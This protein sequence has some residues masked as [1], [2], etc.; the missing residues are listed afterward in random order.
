MCSS[1]LS[2]LSRRAGKAVQAGA[3]STSCLLP[4]VP[5]CEGT[6][7]LPP[8]GASAETGSV[9][10]L[11]GRGSPWG[12]RKVGPAQGHAEVAEEAWALQSAP[13]LCP[14]LSSLTVRLRGSGFGVF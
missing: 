6:H 2:S 5:R 7:R 14:L 9:R 3:L 12:T 11:Q 1:L 8:R 10:C 4:G 13:A